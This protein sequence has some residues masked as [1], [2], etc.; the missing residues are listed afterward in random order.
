MATEVAAPRDEVWRRL[1]EPAERAGWLPGACA[2]AEADGGWPRPGAVLR[3]PVRVRA[4][5]VELRERVLEAV[6]GRR[7]RSEVRLGLHRFEACFT[8]ALGGDGRTRL[9]LRVV[10]GSEIPLVGGSLDRFAVRRRAAE[11][12]AAWLTALRERCES[13]PAPRTAPLADGA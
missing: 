11:L 13:A 2:A 10:T 3:V 5:P 7:L 1:V 9:G 12:A 8:L 6:P 4:L